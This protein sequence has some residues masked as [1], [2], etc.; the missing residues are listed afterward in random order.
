[1]SEGLRLLEFRL[2][3]RQQPAD[4]P[5]PPGLAQAPPIPEVAHRRGEWCR[6]RLLGGALRAVLRFLARPARRGFMDEVVLAFQACGD[7]EGGFARVYCD[8][9]RSDYLVAFSCS[10]RVFCPSCAAKRAAVFGALLHEEILE[11]VGHAAA[12][13]LFR[14]KVIALLRDEELLSEERIELLLSWQNTGR[15]ARD[16]RSITRSPWGRTMLRAPSGLL[17]TCFVR[18]SVS[19]GCP[20]TP[21]ALFS[22][23]ARPGVD[24]VG[25]RPPLMRWT[26]SP[27][28]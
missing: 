19:S 13:L 8:E 21:M 6:R 15:P 3:S 20:W 12:E 10:R 17:A 22:T 1:M 2:D 5:I 27:V 11:D 18:R 28:C 26:S 25:P 14:H 7:F 23:V 4:G 16:S 24:S 9:C